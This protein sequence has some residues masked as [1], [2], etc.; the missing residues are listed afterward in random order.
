MGNDHAV[1]LVID[2]LA[3]IVEELLTLMDLNGISAVGASDLDGGIAILEEQLAIRVISCD[4]RL[5]RESGLDLIE[6]VERHPVLRT[7]NLRFLF[8][9][10]D[11]IQIDRLRADKGHAFLS[12]PV[13]PATLIGTLEHML[14]LT[15]EG[16]TG[17]GVGERHLGG[18]SAAGGR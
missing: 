7:R 11:Q 18:Q 13:Q 12:K 8:V 4:L 17:E 10:G 5:D 14:A 2:N 1:V 3:A 6:R 9:S 16:L 15:D